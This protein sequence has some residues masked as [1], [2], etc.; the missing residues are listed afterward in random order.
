M[1]PNMLDVFGRVAADENFF[2]VA[3]VTG[4]GYELENFRVSDGTQFVIV[5]LAEFRA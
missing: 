2:A 1:L 3:E 5:F 4:F